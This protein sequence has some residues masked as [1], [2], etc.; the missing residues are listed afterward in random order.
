MKRYLLLIISTVIL[1]GCE[2]IPQTVKDDGREAADRA[3]AK[4]EKAYEEMKKD[5]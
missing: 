2:S 3:K 5:M 1:A 4:A